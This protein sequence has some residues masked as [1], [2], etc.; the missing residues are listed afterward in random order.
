MKHL[1]TNETIKTI[2]KAKSKVK[3]SILQFSSNIE[4]TKFDV[5]RY[6]YNVINARFNRFFFNLKDLVFLH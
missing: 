2:T 4:K 3:V 6:L 5:N 1:Q